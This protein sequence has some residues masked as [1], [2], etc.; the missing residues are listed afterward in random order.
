MVDFE[1]QIN[2]LSNALKTSSVNDRDQIA[3]FFA[4][5]QYDSMP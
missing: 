2:V 3:M 4:G 5:H 1:N